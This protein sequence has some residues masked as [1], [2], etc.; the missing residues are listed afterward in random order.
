MPK[1]NL[2][3]EE[4]ALL[5]ECSK[6]SFYKRELP[7]AISGG[8]L[9]KYAMIKGYMNNKGSGVKIFS[10]CAIGYILGKSSYVSVCRRKAMER[11]P[12][13]N[14]V[15][16]LQGLPLDPNLNRVTVP[17]N[18]PSAQ[19]Q[20]LSNDI[21]TN[22]N[23]DTSRPSYDL[24]TNAL[25]TKNDETPTRRSIT[26]EELRQ[27]S[28]A[29]ARGG[30]ASAGQEQYSPMTSNQDYDRRILNRERMSG[31]ENENQQQD[32]PS[33]QNR[34]PTFFADKPQPSR[35]SYKNKYG[36]EWEK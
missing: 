21:Y 33:S 11:L 1:F 13:S 32:V 8:L 5:K 6:E 28:R 2:T 23:I 20:T 31:Q 18:Q 19:S 9:T 24:D 16:G 4:I 27:Q 10:A 15:R 17:E 7:L 26:Y 35:S 29:S 12:N 25:Q 30:M 34:K 36:D 14:L 3:P 22:S